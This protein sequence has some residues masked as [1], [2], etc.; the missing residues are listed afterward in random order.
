MPIDLQQFRKNLIYQ[1]K[2]P[3]ATLIADLQ[4]ITA[5]DQLAELE[6]KKYRKQAVSYFFGLLASI[7]LIVIIFNFNS[8]SVILG[9]VALLLLLASIGL[10]IALIYAL[11]KRAKFARLNISNCRYEVTKKVL[12]MLGRDIDRTTEIEL[13]LSFCP[14][15]DKKNKTET[16]PHPHKNQWKIDK[17]EHEWLKLKGQF[18]DKTRFE[19]TATGLSKMQYGWKR[20]SRGKNKY[21]TK[22]KSLGFDLVL[23][24]VYP[25]RRYGAVKILQNDISAAVKLP[26]LAYM[27]G[28]RM[29]EKAMYMTVRIVPQVEDNL[30]EIYQTITMM[31]LSLYQVLNLAKVLSK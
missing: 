15:T 20:T 31:F 1:A 13:K 26:K 19:L 21:K 5:L 18:L 25:Q 7:A 2:A 23:T 12:L 4:E 14:I 6:Q 8:N 10:T 3:I 17:H 27:R 24:L 22:N 11:V 9:L 29:T 16:I 30:E 28:L